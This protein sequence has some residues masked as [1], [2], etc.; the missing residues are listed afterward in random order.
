MDA[1]VETPNRESLTRPRMSRRRS[2]IGVA[3]ALIVLAGIAGLAWYLLQQNAKPGRGGSGP[4][5]RGAIPT[6]VG[7]AAA[8]RAD[9][10]V[11]ID[12]LGTVAAV[13]VNVRPQVSGVLQKVLFTE[14]QMVKSGQVLAIIDPRPFEMALLQASGQRQRDE[15]QL[16]NARITLARYRTLLEQD[17]IARQDVDTQAALVKQLEGTVATDRAAEGTARINLGY[18]KIVAPID[19]RVG[20]RA[21]DPGN[22]VGP[23]DAN[24]IAAITRV[25]PIDVEFSIPQDR[26]P[27]VR[28]RLGQNATLPVAA[29][30]RARSNELASG[31]F[32]ALDNQVD[33]Q[34]GTVKAKARF[35]NDKLTL[36]PSQ[37]VNVRLHVRTVE[38]AVV[39]PVA[40]VR[41]GSD[42][43]YVYLL[44]KAE[45]TV[46]L[47]PVK[48]GLASAE[49]IQIVSGVKAGD[50][51]ITEG[52]DRLKDG[53]KVMLP[54]DKPSFGGASGTKGGKGN[55]QGSAAPA[56][57][58][59]GPTAEQR[60]RM[61]DQVKDDPEALARRRAF[62]DKIDKGDPEALAR[63]RQ[64]TERRGR[65]SSQ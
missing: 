12:S 8:T 9:I 4:G 65:S 58:A 16:D 34:T 27:E 39:V 42:G 3:I 20:L 32:L 49:Q 23:N 44:N 37:F 41:H 51:V 53:A 33:V 55:G 47:R 30:D 61:L 57:I 14:G 48:R 13:T 22:V 40:A 35:A 17:S 45:R 46:A 31:K 28:E 56:N 62:L 29:L 21:V 11:V 2:L 5:G 7:V 26:V 52:A 50:E 59:Q 6:T 43:D 60:Q 15:A 64:M 1:Q 25:T 18:T 54:G 24:G 36:F 10:P 63:W 19:G 38:G